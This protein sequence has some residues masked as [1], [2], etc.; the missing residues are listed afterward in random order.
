VHFSWCTHHP[1]SYHS[2]HV[3][4]LKGFGFARCQAARARRFESAQV[5]VIGRYSKL[6]EQGER[7]RDL[8]EMVPKGASEVNARTKKQVQRRM[9]PSEIEDLVAGYQD[10]RTVYELADQFRIHRDTVSKLLAREGVPRRYRILDTAAIQ[11]AADLYR[12]GQSLATIGQRLQV[13][14][15]TVRAAVLKAGVRM[16]DCQGRERES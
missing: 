13:N 16:R 2:Y 3:Y 1:I 9:R 15:T 4:A 7:V 5:E 14:P 11:H 8:L 12:S 6:P 10:G